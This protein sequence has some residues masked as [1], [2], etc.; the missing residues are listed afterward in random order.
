MNLFLNS[1][2]YIFEVFI[3]YNYASG[4]FQKKYSVA[5]T[6]LVGI[7]MFLAP[8]TLS[9]FWN[10]PIINIISFFLATSFYLILTHKIKVNHVFCKVL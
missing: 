7:A 5:K 4:L 8:F 10:N 3:I 9:Q 1:L 6:L 2:T